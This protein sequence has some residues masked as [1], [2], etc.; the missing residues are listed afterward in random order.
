MVDERLLPKSSED[1]RSQKFWDGWFQARGQKAFE[2]YGEWANVRAIAAP[3]C[4][5]KS[6]LVVGRF[7][8]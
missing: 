7:H 6:I 2:W 1:F 4:R 5:E 8:D 3:L